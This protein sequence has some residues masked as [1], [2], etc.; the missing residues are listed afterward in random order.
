[1]ETARLVMIN[2]WYK[3]TVALHTICLKNFHMMCNMTCGHWVVKLV[4]AL[5][6]FLLNYFLE[7]DE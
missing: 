1:M 3:N 6:S 5:K 4:V 2:Y 7:T